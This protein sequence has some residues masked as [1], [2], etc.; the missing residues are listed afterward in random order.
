VEPIASHCGNEAIPIDENAIGVVGAC[1]ATTMP[2][3]IDIAVAAGATLRRKTEG[4]IATPT[5]FGADSV[6]FRFQ[7]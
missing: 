1:C 3:Q 7:I 4:L 5:W 2:L 6:S